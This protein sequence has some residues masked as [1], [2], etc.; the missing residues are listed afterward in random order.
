MKKHIHQLLSLTFLFFFTNLS[1]Y[2][3]S[4][5]DSDDYYNWF[6]SVIGEGNTS[7]YNGTRYIEEYRTENENHKFYL[8][9]HYL[10]GSLTYENQTFYN[11]QMRYDLYKDNIIVKL[12]N[13]SSF[14]F[15]KLLKEKVNS[16][17]LLGSK[18]INLAKFRNDKGES[19]TNSFYKILHEDTGVSLYK[20]HYKTR[21]E[22]IKDYKL[23]SK[24]SDKEYYIINHKGKNI[25]IG[26]KKDLTRTFPNLKKFISSY[27]KEHR[28]LYKSDRDNF[29]INLIKKINS[30]N[31]NNN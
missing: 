29:Y 1:V 30:S 17:S 5:K 8:S 6:D 16:F 13:Q 20:K 7:L 27:Y 19:L 11:V 21:N 18:F 12:P 4:E 22:Y 14:L 31:T 28:S 23:Y 25:S 24:F 26:K 3:Q 15:I 2:C 9:N 10:V